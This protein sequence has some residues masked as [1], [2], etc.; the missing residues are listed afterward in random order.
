[1]SSKS[2][3]TGPPSLGSRPIWREPRRLVSHDRLSSG[4]RQ[5]PG[6]LKSS[7]GRRNGIGTRARGSRFGVHPGEWWEVLRAR[8]KRSREVGRMP[9]LVFSRVRAS[10]RRSPEM[11][12]VPQSSSRHAR[13]GLRG[14]LPHPND[15]AWAIKRSRRKP[16]SLGGW[17]RTAQAS[18]TAL[19]TADIEI[20]P[21]EW[22]RS[23][24]TTE[25]KAP[26]ALLTLISPVELKSNLPHSRAH[27]LAREENCRVHP[28]KR[29]KSWRR[30]EAKPL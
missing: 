29:R 14:S 3:R 21:R 12:N 30:P 5:S 13:R 17:R 25:E 19:E 26:V 16:G 9:R 28:R 1:M 8:L 24:R 10:S 7:R 2:W 11:A 27:P 6:L 23:W 18:V 15:W 20:H 22:R 4:W